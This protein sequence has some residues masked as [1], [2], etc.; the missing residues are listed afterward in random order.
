M[1]SM[2]TTMSHPL[3]TGPLTRQRGFTLLEALIALLVVAFGLLAVA[4]FQITMS[5]NSDVAKQRSEAVRLGQQKLEE[6]RS[7]ETV[8]SDGTKYDYV[9]EVATG[10]DTLTPTGSNTAFTRAWAV[11]QDNG[12]T[13]AG[14]ADPAKWVRVTVSW[15]DRE[16]TGAA[17]QSIT[18][19][20]VISRS[21]PIDLGTLAT[22]PGGT[23]TRT[24]KGRNINIPYPAISLGGGKSGFL[25]P[26]ASQFFVFDDVTGEVLGLCTNTALLTAGQ[27]INFTDGSTTTSC[28][29]RPSHLLSGYIRF[30]D[31]PNSGNTSDAISTSA[32]TTLPLSMTIGNTASPN[33]PC[34]TQRQV[35]MRKSNPTS[36]TIASS[37]RIGNLVTV[38]AT[39]NNGFNGLAVG[40][41][42]IV[43]GS[44]NAVF[45]G[46]FVIVTV[47][48]NLLTYVTPGSGSA[49]STGGEV[50]LVQDIIVEEGSTSLVSLS[51]ALLAAQGY[52]VSDRF[53]AYSCIVEHYSTG[54]GDAEIADSWWGRVLFT[55][56]ASWTFGTTS[57]NRKV[58]RF[59]GDYVADNIVSNTEHPLY[60]R[61][62]NDALDNQN[63]LIIPGN[64]SCPTDVE[65]NTATGDYINVNTL[66]HQSAL[67]GTGGVVSSGSQWTTPEP[68]DTTATIPM[69]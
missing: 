64:D 54:S 36:A 9:N 34:Y 60:Y 33:A 55:P 10:T 19:R 12:T 1:L 18:L 53:I 22:G 26:G 4:G 16:A 50:S 52:S 15:Q 58:C 57:S 40:N 8:S 56:D 39:S 43:S 48:G 67:D 2:D 41:R 47:T 6:L 68:A 65:I 11:T 63:Y 62:V 29:G 35:V 21:D 46:E 28:V 66:I 5:R 23:K 37:A 14:A 51:Q 32:E 20:S 69:Q 24:P 7:F 38:T 61:A 42:I 13:A 27:V 31:V 17:N 49:S 3:S 44:S 30:Y 45:D 25:P 59:T